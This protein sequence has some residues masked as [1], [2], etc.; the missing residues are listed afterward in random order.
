MHMQEAV[1]KGGAHR[2][3]EE[4][5]RRLMILRDFEGDRERQ[6]AL[7]V[8]HIAPVQATLLPKKGAET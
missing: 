7:H 4:E 1:A 8:P 6:A 3:A 5:N 2:H